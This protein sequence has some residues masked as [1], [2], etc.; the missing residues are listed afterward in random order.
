MSTTPIELTLGDGSKVVG[1]DYEEALKN[2]VKRIEDNQA[3]YKAEKT[4][5]ETSEQERQRLE[6]E[7]QTKNAPPPVKA[8]E[9]DK[10]RYFELLNTDPIGAQN[11][12]DAHRFSIDRPEDVP[13]AF[14]SLRADVSNLNQRAVTAEFLSSHIDEFPPDGAAAKF[15]SQRVQ[16]LVI[17]EGYPLNIRTMNTAWSELV[18][19][20]VI[21]PVEKKTQTRTEEEVPPN[22]GGAGGGG[23]DADIGKY[24]RMS[25][26]ELEAEMKKA[27]MMR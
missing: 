23:G 21:K 27:G 1:K 12:L 4:A 25:D 26:K 18:N 5:R 14:N 24:E 2:A 9:F 13:G 10:T 11:Y 6:Q 17:N 20:G 22:L 19:E 3:A 8:G 7:L 15:M 16:Q